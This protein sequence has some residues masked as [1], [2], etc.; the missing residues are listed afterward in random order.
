MVR[1]PLRYINPPVGQHLEKEGLVTQIDV[2]V[3]A[4][5]VWDVANPRGC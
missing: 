5:E 2:G 4:Q 3:E 1:I